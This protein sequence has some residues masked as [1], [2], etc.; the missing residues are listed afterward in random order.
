MEIDTWPQDMVKFFSSARQRLLHCKT[1]EV[2]HMEF[3]ELM[4]AFVAKLG[5]APIDI[6]DGFAALEIDGMAFGFI[7]NPEKETLTLVA[8]LG[9]AAIDANGEFGAMMLKANFL[10]E[11][12]KGSTIFQ[13][14]DN[15]SFGVQQWFR[16]VDLDAERLSAEVETMANVAEEW[17]QLLAGCSAVET[18]IK[19]RKSE[20]AAASKLVSAGDFLRV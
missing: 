18:E 5:M 20:D 12:T 3:N 11:A 6:E 9:Q 4:Q 13:N 10:F 15:G 2:N 19:V 17:K 14:P 8:D 7:H 16:I 1:M